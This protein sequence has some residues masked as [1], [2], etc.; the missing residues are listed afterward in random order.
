MICLPWP[1]NKLSPNGRLHWAVVAKAKK[2]ARQEA[3]ALTKASKAK[4]AVSLHLT[5]CP[6][7]RRRYDIDGLLSRCKAYLDGIADAWGVDDNTFRLSMERGEV[8]PGGRVIVEAM[9]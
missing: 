9:E 6:P 1:S 3:W 7:D 5:F 4:P 8:V 2:A